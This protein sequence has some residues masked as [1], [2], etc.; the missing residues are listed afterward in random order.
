MKFGTESELVKQL[1][2]VSQCIPDTQYWRTPRL[3]TEFDSS[4]GRA[5]LILYNLKSDWQGALGLGNISPQWA[6]ALRLLPYRR[7]FSFDDFSKLTCATKKRGF[8][9][10]EQFVELGYCDRV[11]NEDR[12]I[13]VVQPR[14]IVNEIFAVE[15]KLRDW[16]RALSQAFRYREYANQ[17]WVVLDTTHSKPALSNITR[18][19]RLNI[20]LGSIDK[21]GSFSVHFKPK[22]LEPQSL[23]R[24]WQVNAQIASQLIVP[25]H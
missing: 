5:D 18:F 22:R 24:F 2:A 13:K 15:A 16:R 4:F 9:V 11:K 25:C 1:I 19:E 8:S 10:L 17:S 20:G 21:N 7:A 3:A 6:Y 12:W 23:Y 14:V